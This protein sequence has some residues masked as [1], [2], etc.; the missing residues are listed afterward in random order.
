MKPTILAGLVIA[1]GATCLMAQIKVK[2][3]G[4]GDAINALI[5]AAKS[6]DNDATIKAA[7]D[8]ISKYA[9]T[10]YKPTALIMEA[11]AY[12]QKGDDDRAQIYAE[13]ALQADPKNYQA[14][15]LIGETVVDH[16]RE[17]DLD[18]EEKL[19]KAEK[20]LNLSIENTKAAVK[21]NPAI[22]DAQWE[23][24]KKHQIAEA[25]AYVGRLF[26]LRKKFDGAIS[27]LQAAS[28]ASPEPAF[29]VWLATAQVQGG[30]ND[31][32]IA[33]CDKLLAQPNLAAIFKEH[34]T[35][36]KAEAAKAKGK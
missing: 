13:Q 25:Q 16:T 1:L 24:L 11:G 10:E 28:E 7:D 8:L 9:D 15:L 33:T 21:P 30:K 14:P 4:E 32:A 18:K 12:H 34:A 27:N 22:P 26:M 3:K 19:A 6:G 36:I 31:D 29:F 17:N 2:S 20:N 5:N 35:R 23:D